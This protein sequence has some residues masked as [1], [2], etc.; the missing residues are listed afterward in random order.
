VNHRRLATISALTVL[1]VL[2]ILSVSGCVSS[3]EEQAPAA[4]GSMG[5][6]G[7][8]GDVMFAAAIAVA[9]DASLTLGSEPMSAQGVVVSRVIAPR[10]GW[11][12]VR[13]AISPGAV[14]G[15]TFVTKGTSEDV[16][17][18]LEAAEAA[19]ARVAL[20][21]D[22]GSEGDFEFEPERE[23]GTL[24]G[25]VYVDR[26]P[27]ELPLDLSSFGVDVEAN[28][29]MVLVED[30]KIVGGELLVSYLFTPSPSWISV[31]E[32]QDGLPGKRIGLA[33]MGAGEV[34]QL[35]IP[36]VG[37]T[38]SE[39][40]VVTVHSDLGTPGSFE[41]DTDHPLASTDQ[42]Y[43]SANVIVSERISVE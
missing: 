25:P 33:Q 22:R 2:A 41:F 7:G 8:G 38:E 30:Q 13:S 21:V 32:L 14:L 6:G 3:A 35:L 17:V 16:F 19:Q 9:Q 40:L 27:V 12:I 20:H 26:L 29:V 24:D 23:G 5:M 10:D 43:R 4:G 39:Q 34:Q 31:N 1:L 36:L 18:R 28:S 11:V 42:P 37:Q 15:K